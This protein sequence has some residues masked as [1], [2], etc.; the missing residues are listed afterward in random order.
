MLFRHLPCFMAKI[1]LRD[2]LAKRVASRV[3][4]P[5][6]TDERNATGG[7]CSGLP[8]GRKNPPSRGS[9]TRAGD[10]A[11]DGRRRLSDTIRRSRFA[12]TRRPDVQRRRSACA[13]PASRRWHRRAR[14]GIRFAPSASAGNAA[15]APSKTTPAAH[16]GRRGYTERRRFSDLRSRPVPRTRSHRAARQARRG[17]SDAR[18]RSSLRRRRPR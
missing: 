16:G 15:M 8:A 5:H 4:Q 6:S 1:L 12:T 17:R 11:G 14:E 10:V 9:G 3:V 13:A 7:G 18:G 2:A